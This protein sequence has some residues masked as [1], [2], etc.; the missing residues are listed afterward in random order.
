MPRIWGPPLGSGT[1]FDRQAVLQISPSVKLFVGYPLVPWPGVMAL[2]ALGPLFKRDPQSRTH[3]LFGAGAAL[4]AGFIALRASNAHGDPTPG[5]RRQT[6]LGTILAFVDCEYPP[7]LLYL[8]MTLGPA[9]LIACTFEST[10]VASLTSSPHS[11]VPFLFYVGTSRSS[12]FWRWR[13]PGS[14][15]ARS[16]GCLASSYL[17]SP[18]A[19]ASTS[20]A[21][22]SSGLPYSWYSF[23][24]AGGLLTSRDAERTGG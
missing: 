13:W 1:S 20:V 22:I 3:F 12:I 15:L 14:L 21:F 7:S 18:P 16:D 19:T 23:H 8:M 6:W 17:R 9:V 24:F 11:G 4:I 2:A 5:P 10:E